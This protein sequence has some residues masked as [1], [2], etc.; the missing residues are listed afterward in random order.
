MLQLSCRCMGTTN[1]GTLIKLWLLQSGSGIWSQ[2]SRASGEVG[3]CMIALSIV[4]AMLV[5]G[6]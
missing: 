1:H 6:P 3:F 4:T 5:L 2:L